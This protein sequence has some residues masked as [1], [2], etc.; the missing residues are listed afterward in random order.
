MNWFK[1]LRK[2]LTPPP[3]EEREFARCCNKLTP[4]ACEALRLG[5]DEAVRMKHDSVGPEHILL[6]LMILGRGVAANLLERMNCDLE[7][8]RSCIEKQVG[9]G[10]EQRTAESITLTPEAKKIV[11]VASHEASA[12]NH[13]YIGTEH[14]LLGLLRECEGVAG[15]V[16]KGLGVNVE[17]TRQQIL[18]ELEPFFKDETGTSQ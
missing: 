7:A 17:D 18:R 5:R 9:Q 3:P 8:V 12:L 15:Q 2:A 4:R 11:E 16:L 6:G 13:T 10:V 14:I 1:E